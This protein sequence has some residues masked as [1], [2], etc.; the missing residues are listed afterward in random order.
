MGK[1]HDCFKVKTHF[2]NC[3]RKHHSLII[4]LAKRSRIL[5]IDSLPDT[6]ALLVCD[7]YLNARLGYIDA[8]DHMSRTS[9]IVQDNV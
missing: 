2:P 5:L 1:H 4:F 7:I 8:L 6:I 9:L 3:L